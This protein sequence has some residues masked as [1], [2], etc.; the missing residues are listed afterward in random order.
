MRG[1][2]QLDHALGLGHDRPGM[3]IMTLADGSVDIGSVQTIRKIVLLLAVAVLTTL[4]IVGAPRWSLRVEDT[5]EWIGCGLI[6]IC[7]LGRTWCSLY[8]GGRKTSRL[9]TTGPYSVSRNPLYLFS[10]IG[11]VG[12]GAQL[13]AVSVALLAGLFAWIVHVLVV[14]QEERVMLASHGDA[15]RDYVARVPRFLPRLSGWRNAE[16]LEVLPRA[17]VTTFLDACIFLAAIPLA[18]FFEHLQRTGVIP[19]LLRL[20]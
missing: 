12:I 14:I 16:P 15:F 13:G 10:V 18:E 9:V 6:V 1:R 4:F 3:K 17:V 20:P 19:I 5:I 8:I 11:A 2:I 7:I